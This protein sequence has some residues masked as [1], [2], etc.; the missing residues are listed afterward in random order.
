M[1]EK[2]MAEQKESSVLF[3]LKEL[4]NLEEDRIKQEEAD[5]RRKAEAEM[6]A[7]AESDRRSRE[8]EEARMRAEEERRRGDEQRSRE[9][10]ARLEAI[11]HAELERARLETENAARVEATKRQQEHERQLHVIS[12]DEGK[13]RLKLIAGGAA[14]LLVIA[15]VVGGMMFK[16]SAERQRQLETQLSQLNDEKAGVESKLRQAKT[17]EEVEAL[18]S[19][20]AEINSRIDS[21]SKSGP[22]AAAPVKEVHRAPSGGTKEAPKPAAKPAKPCNCPPGDPLCPCL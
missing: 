10:A 22:A 13:K 12:Q 20:I 15:V 21:T 6:Q 7:R 11:R 9:E 1:Q 4:M 17:P 19:Q 3:S 14:A 18:K 16:A 2:T 8:Q 5:R